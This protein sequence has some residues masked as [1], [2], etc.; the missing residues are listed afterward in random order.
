MPGGSADAV[1]TRVT[2][3]HLVHKSLGSKRFTFG[4]QAKLPKSE[5]KLVVDFRDDLGDVGNMRRPK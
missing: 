1:R 2:A 3:S 4:A 5:A